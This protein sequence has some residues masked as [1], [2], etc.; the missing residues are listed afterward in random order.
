M[1]SVI[2]NDEE[3]EHRTVVRVFLYSKENGKTFEV[4]DFSFDTIKTFVNK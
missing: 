2:G 3:N 1:S 4:K